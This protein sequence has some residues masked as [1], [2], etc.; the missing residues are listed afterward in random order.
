MLCVPS[1]DQPGPRMDFVQRNKMEAAAATRPQPVKRQGSADAKHADFGRVPTYL[2][3]RKIEAIE[4]EEEVVRAREAAKI[5]PGMRLLPEHERLETLSVLQRNKAEVERLIWALPLKIET[6][7]QRR[8]KDEL[9][10]RIADIEQGI[11]AFSKPSVIVRA[12]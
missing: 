5:P 12:D 3:Q 2:L 6:L 4:A 11:K 1:A 7:G 9:D 8:R 10:E